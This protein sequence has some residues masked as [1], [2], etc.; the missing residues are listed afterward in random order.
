MTAHVD[1]LLFAAGDE[2]L[3]EVSRL[4]VQTPSLMPVSQAWERSPLSILPGSIQRQ[5]N[6]NLPQLCM[7]KSSLR[8]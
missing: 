4:R 2:L 5:R 6:R 1:L 3:T 7:S 8:H